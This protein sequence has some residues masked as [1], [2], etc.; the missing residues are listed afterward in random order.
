[1]Q[2]LINNKLKYV[3]PEK[4]VCGIANDVTSLFQKY[5]N[6]DLLDR[7]LL[8]RSDQLTKSTYYLNLKLKENL[9]QN[10]VEEIAIEDQ[11]SN[12]KGKFY[13]AGLRNLVQNFVKDDAVLDDLMREKGRNVNPHLLRN[14]KDAEY[15]VPDK[16]DEL[17]LQLNISFDDFNPLDSNSPGT[18]SHKQSAVYGSFSNLSYS[19]QCKREDVFVLMLTKRED[20]DKIDLEEFFEPL[21]SE[22]EEINANPIILKNGLKC[23]I[24]F[25]GICADNL[26]A[27][28]LLR[29]T[30]CFRSRACKYCT[31]SYKELQNPNHFLKSFKKRKHS[32]SI[33]RRLNKKR[34]HF[35]ADLFHDIHEGETL[36]FYEI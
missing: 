12:I 11:S 5:L 18:S 10:K 25:V 14:Y 34:M 17:T 32:R 8:Y 28:E 7:E 27:N 30:K 16:E 23:K 9:S 13:Y 1:M 20:L 2:I 6:Q 3:I 31:I 26:G 22:I 36:I 33:F 19:T 4:A 21:I 24:G 29:I 15:Y 35:I